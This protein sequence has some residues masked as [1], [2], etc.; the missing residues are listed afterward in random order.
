[1]QSSNLIYLGFLIFAST[2]VA[3]SLGKRDTKSIIDCLTAQGVPYATNTSANWTYLQTPYNLRLS[4][5]PAVITLPIF[6]EHVSDSVTC[7]A[8]AGLKVQAKGGGHS[9]AS[10]SSG[11]RDGFVVIDMENF[12]TIVLD[13]SLC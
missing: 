4:Y 7:A 8:E 13:N 1:M 11:G 10:F 9:Y 2:T 12:N 3:A 6:S 5:Q